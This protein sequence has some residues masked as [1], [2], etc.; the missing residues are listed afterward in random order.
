MESS[1]RILFAEGPSLHRWLLLGRVRAL[2]ACTGNPA[3]LY[4][5]H[6]PG[7]ASRP[8]ACPPLCPLPWCVV[9]HWSRGR[10]GLCAWSDSEP[11]G[12]SPAL[13]LP[14]HPGSVCEPRMDPR[15][16]RRLSLRRTQVI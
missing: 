15:P 6:A 13:S 16:A 11:A 3:L 4:S 5:P 7:F 9:H 14:G 10:A 1:R 12:P 8:S 2:P